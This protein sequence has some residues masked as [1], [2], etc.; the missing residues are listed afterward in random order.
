[1]PRPMLLVFQRD[2]CPHI[3]RANPID[4]NNI[5][6]EFT[7]ISGRKIAQLQIVATRENEYVVS[8]TFPSR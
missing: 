8:V 3:N 4:G 6:L 7:Q 2:G 1:M 5:F